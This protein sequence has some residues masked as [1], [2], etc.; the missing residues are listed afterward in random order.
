MENANAYATGN[1]PHMDFPDVFKIARRASADGTPEHEW[2]APTG[3]SDCSETP[4][5]AS[6]SGLTPIVTQPPTGSL[7]DDYRT[8]AFS[9]ASHHS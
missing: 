6:L 2:I 1:H 9:G 8:N 3:G 4:L 5:E 7:R